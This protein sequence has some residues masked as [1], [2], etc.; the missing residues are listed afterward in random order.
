MQIFSDQASIS[1]P[2]TALVN[3]YHLLTNALGP[4]A[5]MDAGDPDLLGQV[6]TELGDTLQQPAARLAAEWDCALTDRESLT[7]AHAQL[8]LGPF[9]IL[10]PP[11]ESLYLDPERRLMGQVSQAVARAYADAGLGPAAGPQEIPDHITRE[12]EFMY[13]TGFQAIRSGE[14]DWSARRRR[15]WNNHLGRW[16]PLLAANIAAAN[17]HPFYNAVAKVL[18]ALNAVEIVHNSN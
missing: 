8:L 1:T 12:L 4:V 14:C 13:F 5:E 3:L 7:I 15:F 18:H 6:A 16:L 9:E 2:P 17:V 11:Y 10:A